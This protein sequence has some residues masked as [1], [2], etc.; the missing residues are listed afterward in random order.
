MISLFLLLF[1]IISAYQLQLFQAPLLDS[2]KIWN[3]TVDNTHEYFCQDNT[4]YFPNGWSTYPSNYAIIF[5]HSDGFYATCTQTI[6]IPSYGLY[7]NFQL[8]ISIRSFSNIVSIFAIWN[9]KLINF[10]MSSVNV[11]YTNITVNI[12]D[13]ITSYQN[14]VISG[15]L[16]KTNRQTLAINGIYLTAESSSITS[17]SEES[18][19][20]SSNI[21]ASEESHLVSYIIRAAIVFVLIV[22]GSSLIYLIYIKYYRNRTDPRFIQLEQL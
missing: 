2:N 17:T 10:N 5:N 4:C 19:L 21:N 6:I 16:I 14:N 13:N 3:F 11:N 22:G 1:S 8:T 18:Y 15:I 12:P 20:A 7:N 9:N